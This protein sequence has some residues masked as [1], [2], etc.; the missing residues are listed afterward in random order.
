MLWVRET[1]HRALVAVVLLALLSVPAGAQ[2][3]SSRETFSKSLEAARQALGYYGIYDNPDELRRV[4]QIGYEVAQQSGFTDYPFS[5]YLVDMPVP[6]AFALP[7]GHVF[8]TRGMLDLGLDDDMLAGLLGHEIAHVVYSHGLKL[9]KRAQLFN[10]LSQVLT[11]GV[12]V[13]ADDSGRRGPPSS[14]YGDPRYGG[15]SGGDRVMGTVAAGMVV[16]ELLLR[17]YSREFEDEADDEGQR[18]AAAAGYDPDGTR[19]LMAL[20]EVRLPQTQEYGYWQTHPFFEDRV[21]S[22]SVREELLKVQEPESADTFRRQTQSTLLDFS[23]DPK[24]RKP[25]EDYAIDLLKYSAVNAWPSGPRSAEIRLEFLHRHRDKVFERPEL[26]RDFGDLIEEYD[27]EAEEVRLVDPDAPLLTTLSDEIDGFRSQRDEIYPRA[28]EIYEAGIFETD[29]LETFAS[30]YPDA[31]EF[32]AVALSL[33]DAYSRLQ[34][35]ADAVEQYLAVKAGS[36]LSDS[37]KRAASGLRV[38]ASR[39]DRLDALQQLIDQEEDDELRKLAETRIL[40]VA[41]S[42]EELENGAEFLKAYPNAMLAD[43]VSERVNRLAENLYG[44]VIL[45]QTVGDHAKALDG[46][47]KILT[48][49]PLSPAAER[50]RERA[51]LDS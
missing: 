44:E 27:K 45:Y 39:L 47:T 10:I 5:F 46:I 34:R 15:G 12:M 19:R 2:E 49:A 21:R 41:G 9:Q 35:P 36:P 20:M 7:G 18:M 31:P 14:V 37:G 1:G 26:A 8:M 28:V 40:A 43:D 17:S 29:F 42:F 25:L 38:L 48:Q 22:A 23:E 16:S 11:V 24:T 3:I 13:A 4:N 30:N 6:N 32:P 33:G 50:L 51:V